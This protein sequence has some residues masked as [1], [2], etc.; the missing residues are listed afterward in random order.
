MRAYFHRV[1]L[2]VLVCGSIQAQN[3]TEVA[4][5]PVLLSVEYQERGKDYEQLAP[6]AANTFEDVRMHIVWKPRPSQLGFTLTNKSGAT[7]RVLWDEASF[8]GVDGKADRV[9]HQGVRFV[10]GSAYRCHEK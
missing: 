7:L 10:E 8:V 6:T 3:A 4:Y 1:V 2:M 5:Q 9:M